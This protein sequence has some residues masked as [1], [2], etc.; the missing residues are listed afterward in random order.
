VSLPHNV[1]STLTE[2]HTNPSVV[3]GKR[4][5][6]GSAK[7]Q[8]M[9]QVILDHHHLDEHRGWIA[10]E[11]LWFHEVFADTRLGW[12]GLLEVVSLVTLVAVSAMGW[13]GVVAV[14]LRSVVG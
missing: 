13:L 14:L 6:H 12:G 9:A 8:N 2:I 3:S 5:A 1:S 10:G 11:R 4:L 7:E